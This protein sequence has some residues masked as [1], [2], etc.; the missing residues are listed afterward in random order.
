M[1]HPQPQRIRQY[2]TPKPTYSDHTIAPMTVQ[3][4]NYRSAAQCDTCTWQIRAM[5]MSQVKHHV[6]DN[7]GHQVTATWTAEETF[8]AQ[9]T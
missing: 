9:Q 4:T 5:T 8:R 2:K 3:E 6:L 1:H 7:P